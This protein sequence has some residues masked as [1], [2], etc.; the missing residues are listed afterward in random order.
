MKRPTKKQQEI[1][2]CSSLMD[3]YVEYTPDQLREIA[4]EMDLKGIQSIE[5]ETEYDHTEF[6]HKRLETEDEAAKRYKTQYAQWKNFK[7]T[8]AERKE[9]QKQQLIKEAKKLGLTVSDNG[10]K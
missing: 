8:A 9:K 10:Q 3:I 6:Y 4:D 7:M 5:V 2:E 1:R